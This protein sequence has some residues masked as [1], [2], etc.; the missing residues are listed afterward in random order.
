MNKVLDKVEVK[1]FIKK[2]NAIDA[3]YNRLNT[4]VKTADITEIMEKTQTFVDGSVLFP[5]E[6]SE[7]FEID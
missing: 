5:E 2:Y 3:I 4:K 6:Q 1:P 7:Y